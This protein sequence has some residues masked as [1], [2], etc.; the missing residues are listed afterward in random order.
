MYS[1]SDSGWME[2]GNFCKWF[3]MLYIPA[4][5]S[6]LSTGPVVLFVDGH[7]SH[8][9]MDVIQSAFVYLGLS[10]VRRFTWNSQQTTYLWK[11]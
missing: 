2:G 7:H 9:T 10:M 3:E 5:Q 1:V 8:L 4:V 6:L 11:N